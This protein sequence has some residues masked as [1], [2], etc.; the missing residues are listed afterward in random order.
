[1]TDQTTRAAVLVPLDTAGDTPRIG[2]AVRSSDSTTHADDVGFPG[3][4]PEP[5]DDALRATA[6]RETREE[7]ALPPRAFTITD[8]LAPHATRSSGFE[9]HPFLAR[10]SDPDAFRPDSRELTETFWIAADALRE[11]YAMDGDRV[12]YTVTRTAET[13]GSHA[14]ASEERAV[15]GVTARIVTTL[16]VTGR[17][18]TA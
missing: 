6:R 5:A 13:N 17:L 4:T 3:G 10:V 11:G 15:W 9:L 12:R 8:K 16:L 7:T 14:E 1:M 18:D 2:F